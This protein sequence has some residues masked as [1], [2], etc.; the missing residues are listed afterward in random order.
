MTALV[1]GVFGIMVGFVA[2]WV[3]AAWVSVRVE[4]EE[5]EKR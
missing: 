2:G 1:V 3:T 4:R 5:G